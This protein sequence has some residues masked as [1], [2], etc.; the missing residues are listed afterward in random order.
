MSKTISLLALV[1]IFT[2]SPYASGVVEVFLRPISS[3]STFIY[4]YNI[5]LIGTFNQ[6]REWCNGIGGELPILRSQED[7]DFL[8][9]KVVGVNKSLSGVTNSSGVWIGLK[10]VNDYCL[11][12]DGSLEP[13]SKFREKSSKD[14]HLQWLSLCDDLNVCNSSCCAGVVH[15]GGF[16]TVKKVEMAS[17]DDN[18]SELTTTRQVCVIRVNRDK[19]LDRF[20][21]LTHQL[22]VSNEEDVQWETIRLLISSRLK[23]NERNIEK[24]KDALTVTNADISHTQS[25]INFIYGMIV[26][27]FVLIAVLFLIIFQR[28][29][30]TT[31]DGYTEMY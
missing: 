7:V 5:N 27:Q 15:T 6:T 25:N 24:V 23:E 29:P 3:D 20:E 26:V 21:N 11:W 18:G 19:V 8:V 14:F 9:E 31:L 2:W 1:L 12:L 22:S 13:S 4:V 16:D 17:C 28:R 30:S 10:R